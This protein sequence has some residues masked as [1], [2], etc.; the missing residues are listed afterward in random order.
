MKINKLIEKDFRSININQ[1]LGGLTQ[2]VRKSRRN[3]YPVINDKGEF[4]GIIHLDDIRDL[5]FDFEQFDQ[6][7]VK[8]LCKEVEDTIE[9]GEDMEAVMQKFERTGAWNLP[10]IKKGK[11]AGFVSKSNIFNLYRRT[12]IDD[13]QQAW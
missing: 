3:L 13:N 4:M 8:N 7:K 6:V 12:V 5:M 1:N 11:Y 9:Y 10:V 2:V